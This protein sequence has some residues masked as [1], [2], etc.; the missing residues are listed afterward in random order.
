[1]YYVMYAIEQF[2]INWIGI[3]WGSDTVSLDILVNCFVHVLCVCP[4]VILYAYYLG[5]HSALNVSWELTQFVLASMYKVMAYTLI[6]PSL[7][8]FQAAIY[9]QLSPLCGKE[10]GYQFSSSLPSQ[11]LSQIS[12]LQELFNYK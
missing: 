1:M 11:C 6:Y 7:L 5:H 8:Y 2:N 9:Q 10:H 3:C 12:E 4:C